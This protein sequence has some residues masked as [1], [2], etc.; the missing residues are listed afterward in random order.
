MFSVVHLFEYDKRFAVFG[1]TFYFYDYNRPENILP[2]CISSY[3]LVIADPPF[4]S[5]EC[6]SKVS[7]AIKKLLQEGGK[8]ILCTGTF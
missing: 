5:E 8:I 6:L 2:E 4:L 3:N 7:V 1:P